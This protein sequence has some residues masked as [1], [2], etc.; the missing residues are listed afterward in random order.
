MCEG[1]EVRVVL[2]R[3]LEEDALLMR[4]EWF[5]GFWRGVAVAFGVG[6]VVGG[7]IAKLAQVYG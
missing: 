4:E 3:R 6:I 1:R 5:D 7:V 2:D